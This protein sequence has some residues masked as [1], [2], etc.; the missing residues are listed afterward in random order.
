MKKL[1]IAVLFLALALFAGCAASPATYTVTFDGNGQKISIATQTVTEGECAEEPTAPSADGYEFGGWYMNADCSGNAYD[2]KTPVTQDLTLYARWNSLAE[3]QS[4]RTAEEFFAMG[5]GNYRLENDLDLSGKE[6]APLGSAEEPFAGTLDGNGHTVSGLTDSLFGYV[7]GTVKNLTVQSKIEKNV[8]GTLYCGGVAQYVEGG[9]IENCVAET[10]ISI[11]SEDVRL[12]VYVGGI[13][14]RNV[15]GVIEKCTA[16]ADI[17]AENTANVYAGGVVGYN[18]GEA[19]RFGKVCSSSHYGIVSAQS[20]GSS[21]SAYAGGVVGYNGGEISDSFAVSSIVQ[22]SC[23]DYHAFAGGVAGDNNGGKLLRCFSA[24]DVTCTVVGGDTFLGGVTGRNF[25]DFEQIDC[26]GWNGQVLTL[27]RT[28]EILATARH[29][30]TIAETVPAAY[31]NDAEWYGQIGLQGWTIEDG[32]LPYQQNTEARSFARAASYGTEGNPVKIATAADLKGMDYGKAYVLTS[33]IE[34]GEWTAIGSYQ[35]PFWGSLDGAGHRLYGI[36]AD[37][38]GGY[39]GLF[40][41]LNGAVKNVEV[42]ISYSDAGVGK[43]QLYAGGIAAFALDAMI[44]NCTADV[45]FRLNTDGGFAGG[46]I[47]Y[48]DGA[49]ISKCVVAGYIEVYSSNP[50]SYAA[51]I[52]AVNDGGAVLQCANG[53]TANA[54]GEKG[55]AAGGIVAK[56][57]GTVNDCYNTGAVAALSKEGTGTVYAGGIAANNIG[58]LADCYSTG[59]VVGADGETIAAG[60]VCG[61]NTGSIRNCYAM[62][63]DGMYTVGFSPEPFDAY[64]IQESEFASLAEKLNAGRTVWKDGNGFPV[65]AWQEA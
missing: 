4:V 47:G 9:R 53:A 40:G 23:G 41:Y 7:S 35:T 42:E 8:T 34:L 64:S 25:L 6:G 54:D 61:A 21:A 44:E 52:C 22:A 3:I 58:V 15:N 57:S 18:G 33:D 48:G 62:E 60:T 20:S 30:R 59:M 55:G 11:V 32:Y 1:L 28:G 31:L 17:E 56:N 65:L 16:Y 51:G 26:Y 12:S 50:S 14:G 49:T 38:K 37:G 10:E 2:F 27:D 29:R 5:S 63:A 39:A 19:E 43:G 36:E 46:I 45:D 24:A 13:A